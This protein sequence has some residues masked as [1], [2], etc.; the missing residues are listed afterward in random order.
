MQSD[1]AA[2]TAIHL[3]ERAARCRAI[4]GASSL[5]DGVAEELCALADD[6]EGDAQRLEIHLERKRP[7]PRRRTAE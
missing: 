1:P 7:H 6:Y 5:P 3:R 2:L 4:A